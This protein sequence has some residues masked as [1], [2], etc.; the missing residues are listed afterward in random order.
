MVGMIHE[1]LAFIYKEL[2]KNYS[3]YSNQWVK[4]KLIY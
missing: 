4:W 2:D 3:N 1:K